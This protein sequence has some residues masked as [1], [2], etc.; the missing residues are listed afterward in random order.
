[1]TA[2]LPD[3]LEAVVGKQSAQILAREDTKLNQPRPRPG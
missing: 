3:Q 2:A 1:V